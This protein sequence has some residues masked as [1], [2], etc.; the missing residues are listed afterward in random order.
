MGG[1]GDVAYLIQP[2]IGHHRVHDEF[3]PYLKKTTFVLSEGVS[4]GVPTHLRGQGILVGVVR[5]RQG[6][7]SGILLL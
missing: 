2:H 6:A 7:N 1:G 5:L 4:T 3:S